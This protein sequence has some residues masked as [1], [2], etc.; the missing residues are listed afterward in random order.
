MAR[1]TGRQNIFLD[2]ADRQFFLGKLLELREKAGFLIHA[3]CLMGNHFH[4][5]LEMANQELSRVMQRLLTAHARRFNWRYGKTGHLLEARHKQILVS[6]DAYFLALVRYI[7]LNPVKDGFSK[8]PGSWAWSGHNEL[9]SGNKKFLDHEF[10][11]GYFGSTAREAR[12]EYNRFVLDRMNDPVD[13]TQY[14]EIEPKYQGQIVL[15]PNMA[16]AGL[17]ERIAQEGSISLGEL[18]SG[19]RKAKAVASRRRLI[20]SALHQG[21]RPTDIAEYL[22]CTPSAV[23]KTLRTLGR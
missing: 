6:R 4:L 13:E 15:V 16:L 7:H 2:D 14:D 12:E 3:Y 10:V 8:D 1:G 21:I 17:G 9:V 19:T 5:L 20:V 18:R 11:L 22:Q 23:S